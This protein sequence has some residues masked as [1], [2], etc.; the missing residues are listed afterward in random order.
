MSLNAQAI[1]VRVLSEIEMEL[2]SV[3]RVENTGYQVSQVRNLINV[4]GKDLAARAAWPGLMKNLSMTLRQAKRADTPSD[5]GRFLDGAVLRL[6]DADKIRI[7]PALSANQYRLVES[8]ENR[9]RC[10][11]YVDDLTLRFSKT[12]SGSLSGAYITKLW[13]NRSRGA[14][15]DEI[16]EQADRVRVP[17]HLIVMG[18][19]WRWRRQ[20]GLPY[21]SME[22]DYDVAIEREKAK[23]QVKE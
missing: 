22:A 14:D 20:K 3:T 4:A 8:D 16:A 5:F 19:V 11:Y 18:A 23:L 2:H 7:L 17:D 10:F 13:V 1:F 15:S 21:E 6:E 12:L 9:D